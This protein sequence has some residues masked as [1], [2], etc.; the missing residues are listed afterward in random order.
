[1]PAT[2]ELKAS[3]GIPEK[4][5]PMLHPPPRTAPNPMHIPPTVTC[6]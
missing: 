3:C 4:K 6:K 2:I 5:C 1:M